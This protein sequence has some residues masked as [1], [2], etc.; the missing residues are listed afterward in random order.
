MYGDVEILSLTI[1]VENVG[2]LNLE[3]Y[4]VKF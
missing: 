1:N 3:I 4:Q 2:V